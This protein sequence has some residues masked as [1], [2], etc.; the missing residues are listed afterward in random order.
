M[1]NIKNI[2]IVVLCFVR[3]LIFGPAKKKNI[4]HHIAVVQVG[5]LGDMVCTTPVFRAI[6]K[7]ISD[8]RITVIGRGN[9]NGALLGENPDV[10]YYINR[11]RSF[12][13]LYQEIK[14]N[15][16][17]AAI[18]ITPDFMTLAA[19]LLA[20]VPYIIAA[21]F[22]GEAIGQRLYRFISKLAV[23]YH[24]Y[25]GQYFPRQYLTSLELFDIK[26][27]DT[28]KHLNFSKLAEQQADRILDGLKGKIKVCISPSAGN[29]IKT[30]PAKSFAQVADYLW[31]RYHA[32][33]VIIGAGKG[34]YA[35]GEMLVSLDAKTP[36]VNTLDK[37]SIDEMK[38]LISKMDIFLSVDT[39]PIYVAEAFGVATIDIV[40]PIDETEQPPISSRNRIVSIH[41]EHV[42]PELSVFNA[43]R[44]N[45]KEA[46][47]QVESITP[48]MVIT[49][50]DKLVEILGF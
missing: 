11:Q 39:G 23:S 17:D 9:I 34:A 16:F 33:L 6:K 13:S 37:L 24:L 43:R 3:G 29:K 48:S 42:L 10:N 31:S 2:G 27:T 44:Y 45:V 5:Q 8:C 14:K 19:L 20:G 50:F 15:K 41:N 30:W 32:G 1:H 4:P 40:G 38:A 49:E 12:Y 22:Q 28:T 25:P 47:R 36:V 46:R 35:I 7:H 18:L 21:D 26:E